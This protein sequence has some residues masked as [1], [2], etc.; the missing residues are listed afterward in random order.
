M[1][2]ID[3]NGNPESYSN[4]GEGVDFAAPGNVFGGGT[5]FSA[6]YITAVAAAVKAVH[7]ESN[8]A[9]IEQIMK[10]SCYT[11]EQLNWHDSIHRNE[12]LRFEGLNH[13]ED[14]RTFTQ[15]LHPCE[16]E[17]LYY[18]AGMPNFALAIGMEQCE[19]VSF[20]VDPGH[21]R[22]DN[23]ALTLSGEE[24]STIY[25]TD[26]GSFPTAASNL[27]TTNPE[28]T[29]QTQ[30]ISIEGIFAIRAVA[31]EEGKAPSIITAGEYLNEHL[32]R[33]S[34]LSYTS[35]GIIRS[36]TGTF[37][38]IVI[39][40]IVNGVQVK[41]ISGFKTP[42]T[43]L[44]CLTL[45]ETVES[46]NNNNSKTGIFD[47]LVYFK[48]T[49]MTSIGE[50]CF[51]QAPLCT[52]E[53]PNV[54]S[55]SQYAFYGTNIRTAAFP[56]ASPG[57]Y[58]FDGCKY[59]TSADFSLYNQNY[60]FYISSYAFSGCYRLKSVKTN[61]G[62]NCIVS[63]YAFK[64]CYSL[65]DFDF[66]NVTMIY[67]DA[68]AAVK[69]IKAVIAP[70]LKSVSSL[71]YSTELL[72]APAATYLGAFPF[73]W[74]PLAVVPRS[75][76]SL[77]GEY[78]K[79]LLWFPK[80]F[81]SVEDLVICAA[82]DA[83]AHRYAEENEFRFVSIP[84]IVSEPEN[85]GT[86]GGVLTAD[87]IGIHLSYQWY[88]TN[89]RNN[90][91][92][93]L[94]AGETARQ[95]DSS[96]YAFPYYYCEATHFEPTQSTADEDYVKSIKTGYTGEDVNHDNLVDI[97]DVSLILANVAK[98]VVGANDTCDVDRNGAIDIV[99][100]SALLLFDVFGKEQTLSSL[101]LPAW[102]HMYEMPN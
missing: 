95:L 17:R 80:F 10:D 84:A 25:Y 74:H 44:T 46:C 99:D 64:D 100:V 51:F 67:S 65:K 73:A 57:A 62:K 98:L 85:M 24:G 59:L 54:T 50:Y 40:H 41:S 81:N 82:E 21:Y 19:Q 32:A 75:C 72:Y 2:A 7:P 69:G 3:D 94:L 45:P 91:A 27:Y 6:P 49:G 97:G 89:V 9:Q 14:Y 77:G 60:D 93:T 39:P 29:E 18:G 52:A 78:I 34:E 20:S 8:S 16:D 68:F 1:A 53:I 43:K 71:P 33:E 90:R 55:I 12:G 36:Y 88:G 31:F 4:Y 42:N 35:N 58:S 63:S 101:D 66:S 48:A 15:Y 96:K 30:S 76:N 37:S 22:R 28:N 70:K 38:A 26:D 83:V 87:I 56:Y 23:L 5:S 47:A 61:P 11:F 86:A 13:Y 102:E 92:G 79:E